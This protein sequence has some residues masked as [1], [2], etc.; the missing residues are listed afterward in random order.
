MDRDSF[1]L[2][3]SALH[4]GADPRA[5]L[6]AAWLTVVH[7]CASPFV[8]LR[9]PPDALTVAGVVTACLTPL[10]VG[11]GPGGQAA[12]VVIIVLSGLTDSL[13]GA[14][15]VMTDRVTRWGAVLDATA[16]RVADA[17]FVA[18]LWVAGAP[19]WACVVAVGLAWLLEYVRA[20]AGAAGMTEVAV[21]SVGERPTRVIVVVMFL[22]A[23]L[24]RPA[25]VPS[26]AALGAGAL[27]ILGLVALGQLLVAVRRR[28]G[29][30]G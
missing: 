6:V 14:V 17:A 27:G 30:A 16:D 10:L 18:A 15:A 19:A 9:V 23:D 24:L 22:L 11:A 4:G 13:D 21:L 20:R 1:L 26:W 12:A 5:R 25:A 3:W 8:R 28:L 7:A 2:R 29:V